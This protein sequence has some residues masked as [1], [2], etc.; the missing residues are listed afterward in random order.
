MKVCAITM[1]Y[2][3]YWALAQWIRHYSKHL[4]I[5]N[6]YVVAHGPDDKVNEIAKGAN[7]WTIPRDTLEGFDK[8]RNK[9]LNQFQS[10]LLQFYDWVVRTDTDELV[11]LDPTQYGSISNLLNETTEDAVFSIGLNV[12]EQADDDEM[13]ADVSVFE[14]RTVAVIS[15]NY[16]KAWAVRT[17]APLM[18]HGGKLTTDGG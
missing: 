16:S 4:G 7:I 13:S 3:D 14:S 5:E 9:M 18:R 6:L 8:R 15:G 10:G 12:F 1:V 2:R 11:C 17:D